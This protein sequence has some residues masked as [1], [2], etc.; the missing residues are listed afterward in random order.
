MPAKKL[1]PLR[2]FIWKR[3]MQVHAEGNGGWIPLSLHGE[4][5]LIPPE[6]SAD[7]GWLL[8]TITIKETNGVIYKI[9][10]SHCWGGQ[11][12]RSIFDR[13]PL[14]RFLPRFLPGYS[15]C[16]TRWTPASIKH[17]W[18]HRASP[19]FTPT[20][21]L[22]GQNTCAAK[23]Q[24]AGKTGASQNNNPLT[25]H[26]TVLLRSIKCYRKHLCSRFAERTVG[27]VAADTSALL[28]GRTVWSEP[29]SRVARVCYF[30]HNLESKSW[31]SGGLGSLVYPHSFKLA[32]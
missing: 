5:R 13:Q 29:W 4:T 32:H 2:A 24:H 28:S 11:E 19:G 25:R 17:K 22:R 21:F 12:T 3:Q 31:R 1:T 10:G 30:L 8:I 14:P 23:A 27:N 26:V 15:G 18:P 9:A 7:W 20:T 6:D 16:Y